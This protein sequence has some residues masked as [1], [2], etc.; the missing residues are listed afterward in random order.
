MIYKIDGTIE[1][2]ISMKINEDL[3]FPDKIKINKAVLYSFNRKPREK[4]WKDGTG[5]V[6]RD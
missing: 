5:K 4:V 1:Q 3:A 6:S 2:T